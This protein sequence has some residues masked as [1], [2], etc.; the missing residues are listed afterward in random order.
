[1]SASDL[2]N[3][4]GSTV[5]VTRFAAGAYV[6]GEYVA[7]ATST[8]TTIMSIQPMSG[9]ELLNLPEAQ[10]TRQYAKGFASVE[11]FTVQTSPS[12]R[13]DMIAFQGK[14]YEVQ[15]VQYWESAGSDI[16]PH[17]RV[18]LAEDNPT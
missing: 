3:D 4:F 7:G 11:L 13:A 10:R 5:T 9:R 17:W 18:E 12:K 2:I 14:N 15:K 6:N 8:F 16:A 1:M